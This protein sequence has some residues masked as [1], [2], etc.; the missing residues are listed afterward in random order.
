MPFKYK[1]QLLV[2]PLV[3]IPVLLITLIFI[4]NTR[5]SISELQFDIMAFKLGVLYDQCE[6]E[7]SILARLNLVDS[8]FYIDNAQSKVI[9]EIDKLEI[10]GGFIYILEKNN[11]LFYHPYETADTFVLPSEIQKTILSSNDS[12]LPTTYTDE[13]TRWIAFHK[14]FD[15]WNWTL[16]AVAKEE[17]IYDAIF[18]SIR[19]SFISGV[20]AIIIALIFMFFISKSISRPIEKLI[21][22]SLQLSKGDLSA[23]VDIQTKDEFSILADSFN[24]MA[25]QLN[26]SFDKVQS[27]MHEIRKV[28]DDLQNSQTLLKATFNQAYQLIGILDTTGTFIEVNDTGLQ[29]VNAIKPDIIGHYIWNTPF[30][31]GSES[32]V[33]TI[34][35][36]IHSVLKGDFIR[37]ETLYKGHTNLDFSMKPVFNAQHEVSLIIVEAR[38]ITDLKISERKLMK[39]NEELEDRVEQRTQE[40]VRTNHSLEESITRLEETQIELINTK[41]ELESSLSTLQQTQSQLIESE[42]LAG[43]GAVVAGI[44]HEINTPL[45]IA[46]TLTSHI[47]K[48]IGEL[49]TKFTHQTLS[50]SEMKHYLESVIEETGLALKNLSYASDLIAGFKKIAV[51]QSSHERRKF[52]LNEYIQEIRNTLNPQLKSTGHAIHIR[53]QDDIVMDSFPGAIFQIVNNLVMNSL[54]HGFEDIDKGIIDIDITGSTHDVYITYSDNGKGI[55]PKIIDRVFDP[56]FTTARGRGGSGLGLHIV[57][58]LCT[59]VLNGNITCESQLDQGVIFN[60]SLPKKVYS[61]LKDG[62]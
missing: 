6:N 4:S 50:R 35:K 34:Q 32:E 17:V 60:I 58:N 7:H 37:M 15:P 41:D 28:S 61:E 47:Q 14:K 29:F 54:I 42:K 40:L 36:M 53:C 12:M 33:H 19:L 55:D 31:N 46:V 22:S 56:F 11:T 5:K 59:S 38:D 20:A 39:L 45:G 25:Q 18:D 10:P 57:F 44:S 16:V 9:E 2:M 43:L 13:S 21:K 30:W 62:G 48:E 26:E 52:N 24:T 49:N 1:L 23:R 3:I 51:D 8:P 27:S